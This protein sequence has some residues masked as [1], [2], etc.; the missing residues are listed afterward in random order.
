[1]KPECGEKGC[2]E[3]AAT[4]SGGELLCARCWLNKYKKVRDKKHELN[5]S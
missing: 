4:K 1:M 5:Y 2:K 3:I